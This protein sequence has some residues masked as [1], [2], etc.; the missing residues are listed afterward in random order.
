MAVRL[1][2]RGVRAPTSG[3]PVL[4][5]GAHDVTLIGPAK[6]IEWSPGSAQPGD[7]EGLHRVS[8]RQAFTIAATFRILP[9]VVEVRVEGGPPP[10][11]PPPPPSSRP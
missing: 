5:V 10:S 8:E 6:P 4:Q 2:L 1:L 9:A 11:R 3:P 7:L